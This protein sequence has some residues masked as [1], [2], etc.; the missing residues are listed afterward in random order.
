MGIPSTPALQGKLAVINEGLID[1][2]VESGALSRA[3]SSRDAPSHSQPLPQLLLQPAKLN[4]ISG[5]LYYI[6]ISGI[7]EEG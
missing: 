4:L 5:C 6:L 2:G 3:P 1:G 7:Q